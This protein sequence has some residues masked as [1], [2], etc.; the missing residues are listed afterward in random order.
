MSDYQAGAKARY[1]FKRPE[2]LLAHYTDSAAVFEHILPDRELRMSPYRKMR[3][4]VESQ[5]VLPVIS[6]W[7]DPPGADSAPWAVLE[8]VKATRDAMRVLAFSRDVG[9]GVGVRPG[10]DCCWA[11]PRM[12]EQYGDNHRGACLLFD[13]DRL[14]AFLQNGVGDERIYWDDVR[15]DRQGIAGSP[16]Q[17]VM[18]A[19]VFDEKQRQ[20]AVAEHIDRYRR[21]FFFL[22]SDD[23]ATEAEYRIVLKTDD[24]APVGYTTDDQG[25]AYVGYGDALV[26]VVLGLHFPKW[27]RPGAKEACDDAGIKMLRMWWERGD[28]LLLGTGQS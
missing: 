12:W 4:P 2:G 14:E 7:G 5:D 15:Y 13:R 17:H 9:D 6:G 16:V 1:S 26:A 27:Q 21:D 20:Q 10:F 18:D 3:D 22:K 8:D 11:R 24:D 25:F 19:R 28:P 23:F